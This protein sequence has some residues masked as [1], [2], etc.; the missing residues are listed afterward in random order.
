VVNGAVWNCRG[1]RSSGQY[2]S[3]AG[4]CGSPK[5]GRRR[6]EAA[7][8]GFWKLFML[9]WPEPSRKEGVNNNW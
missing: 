3:T 9:P 8:W 4:R 1:G 2:G 6:D 5:A 7:D